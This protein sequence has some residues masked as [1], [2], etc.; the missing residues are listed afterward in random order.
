MTKPMRQA[1]PLVA[2]FI[3]D[4]RSAFGADEINA[5]IRGGLQ[6]LPTFWAKEGGREIGCRPADHGTGISAAQMVLIV[7]SKD[8]A[9]GRR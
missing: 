8:P 2:S 3:D 1:M 6:G 4:L 5:Q 9:N 7:P